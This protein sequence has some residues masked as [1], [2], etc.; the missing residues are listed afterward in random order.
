MW[1]TLALYLGFAPLLVAGT[2]LHCI[3]NVAVA[4][5][6]MSTAEPGDQKVYPAASSAWM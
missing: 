3:C 5:A 6:E 1:A 2:Q 4:K